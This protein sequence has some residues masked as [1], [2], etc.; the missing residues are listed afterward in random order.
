[1]TGCFKDL[2]VG[3]KLSIIVP[4]LEVI[5]LLH[6][7]RNLWDS[8]KV[9]CDCSSLLAFKM[10]VLCIFIRFTFIQEDAIVKSQL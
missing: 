7:W 8:E 1:M 10:D 9:I 4:Y 2:T 3:R 6:S 5:F